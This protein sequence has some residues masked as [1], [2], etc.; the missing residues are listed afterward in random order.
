MIST[1]IIRA[2]LRVEASKF[3]MRSSGKSVVRVKQP[4]KFWLRLDAPQATPREYSCTLLTLTMRTSPSHPAS[5][6][7]AWR[8]RVQAAGIQERRQPSQVHSA[9]CDRQRTPDSMRWL[10]AGACK[11]SA[12]GIDAHCRARPGKRSFDSSAQVCSM[13]CALGM[14]LVSRPS[15]QDQR[16]V[17][18][19]HDITREPTALCMEGYGA[20]I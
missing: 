1:L 19:K 14:A 16:G 18:R 10:A 3:G 7:D 9:P 15:T 13:P 20:Q 8:R 12:P 6:D 11:R 4:C 17:F 5:R 2:Q